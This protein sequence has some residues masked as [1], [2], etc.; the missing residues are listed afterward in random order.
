MRQSLVCQ[1]AKA[2]QNI[3]KTKARRA[4]RAIPPTTEYVEFDSDDGTRHAAL[5]RTL[6]LSSTLRDKTQNSLETLLSTRGALYQT[7][8]ES[9]LALKD[10][11]DRQRGPPIPRCILEAVLRQCTPTWHA[12]RHHAIQPM[13]EYGALKRLQNPLPHESRLRSVLQ[14]MK[15]SNQP[16]TEDDF[17]FILQQMAAVG[18]V[19]GAA[20]VLEEMEATEGVKPS[21]KT[22]KHILR[23]C[24]YL[25]ESPFPPEV[26]SRVS[27]EVTTLA[28]QVAQRMPSLNVELDAPIVEL[29]LRIFKEQQN[30]E[31]CEHILRLACS[32]D[33]HRPDRMP[34]EFEK[35]LKDADTRQSPLPVPVPVTTSMLTTLMKLYG[36]QGEISKMITTF[37]VLTNPY[38]LPSNLPSPQSD[39]W[40]ADDEYD[41][42]NPV[43]QTPLKHRP[44]YVWDPPK[45]SPNTATFD[46]IIRYLA[47][48]RQRML[49]E[50]YMLLAEEYD[51][52]ESVRLRNEL[53]KE[54]TRLES[55]SPITNPDRMSDDSAALEGRGFI[56]APRFHITSHMFHP[57]FVYAN[58]A[59]LT[60]LMR[61]MQQHLRTI[62]WRRENDLDFF[63]KSYEVLPPS[64]IPPGAEVRLNSRHQLCKYS[65]IF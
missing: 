24:V 16:P 57:V 8:W 31:A 46:T 36:S 4:A 63:K 43:I 54:L 55:V 3:I 18:H 42:A 21:I 44:E 9:Y 45:S 35:R 14:Y 29:M 56:E 19:R 17:H 15:K 2:L 48:A 11:V 41:V 53:S 13:T 39:W 27:N 28:S 1:S 20:S 60:E 33:V 6:S 30:T 23:S 25:M 38:P 26:E 12:L 7:V 59:R 40:D 58:Q 52:A 47:W 50:H 62:I 49:C 51:K 22:F 32:F 64:P 34:E 37:E 5:P 65:Y 10:I 61:W